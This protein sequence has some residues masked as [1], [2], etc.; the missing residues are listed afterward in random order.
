[1]A[2]KKKST[3]NNACSQHV[4]AD[5]L[6]S[7]KDTD[8]H[9]LFWVVEGV[10]VVFVYQKVSVFVRRWGGGGGWERACAGRCHLSSNLEYYVLLVLFLDLF[11][12]V[13][14]SATNLYFITGV[15]V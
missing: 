13:C 12:I 15:I 11:S 2:H 5:I 10:V 1:M 4:L 6:S 7:Y 9:I 14:Y 3:K 8:T